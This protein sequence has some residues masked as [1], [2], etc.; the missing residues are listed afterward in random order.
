LADL[1]GSGY[2]RPPAPAFF[3]VHQDHDRA[4]AQ[5]ATAAATTIAVLIL[6]FLFGDQ[7]ATGKR[8]SWA[9]GF[10]MLFVD[11]SLPR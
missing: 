7:R 4:D 8:R 5:V 1:D 9:G 2:K 10:C 11:A 3:A 6:N